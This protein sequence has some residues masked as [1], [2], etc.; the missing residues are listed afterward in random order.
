MKKWSLTLLGLC[1]AVM[2]MAQVISISPPKPAFNEKATL[3]FRA[4]EGNGSLAGHTGD[5]YLHAGL[6]TNESTS[7]G[8]WKKAVADWG[9]NKKSP[10][11]KRISEDVYELAFTVS[12][13]YGIPATGGGVVALA[14][15]FRDEKGSKVGKDEGGKDL[16]YFYQEPD[17][18]APP[19]VLQESVSR[20][21]D[22]ANYASIY[23]VNIR[24]YTPEGTFNAFAKHLPRLRELGV[25]ILWFMPVQPIGEKRR[26]GPL[27]SYYSIQ[28]YTAINPEFGTMDDFK[29]LVD[30][31][32]GMGFKV[33]LDWVA[34]HSSW[35]NKWMTRHDD[36]Y[37]RDADGNMVAPYDWTD[38]ADL[39][40]DMYYMRQAMTE[41]MLFWVQEADIDGF[42]CDVA[43]EV[44]LDFWEETR[45]QLDALKDV[46][47]LAE[48]GSQ[49]GLLNRAFNANYGWHFHHLMNEVA[50]GKSPASVL[51]PHFED[52]K[53]QYPHGTYPMQFITNHDE[54]SWAGTVYER[55]GDGHKAF[56]VLTFTV[57]GMPLIYSGQ[58]AGL[59]KRLRFFDK[60]TIDWSDQTL[61]P[62]YTQLN[63]LKAE[64]PA[65]WNGRAGGELRAMN[66]DQLDAVVAFSR[67][68]GKDKV[69]TLL[70]L[71]SKPQKAAIEVTVDAGIYTDYFTGETVTLHKRTTLTLQPWE[72]RVLIFEKELAASTRRLESIDHSPQGLRIVTNDGTVYLRALSEQAMELEF[73][74]VGESSIAPQAQVSGLT[75]IPAQL[76]KKSDGYVYATDGIAAHLSIDPL[77]VIYTRNGQKLISEEMGFFDAGDARGFRFAL[78]DG[79]RLTGGGSRVLPI[80]RRGYRLPLY[81][82][83]SYGYETHAEQ[84]YYSMPMLLSDRKYALFFDN[85]AVGTLDV[86]ATEAEILQFEAVGGRMSYTVVAADSW[87]QLPQALTAVTGRQPMLPRWALGNIASRMGYHSQAEVTDVVRRYRADDIP[88]D[89]VVLDLFWFGATVKN[90]LGNLDWH[91]DS[92]PDPVQMMADF[93]ADGVNTILITEPFVVQGTKYADEVVSQGLVGKKAD[94]SPYWYDFFF[95]HTTLLDLFNPATQRW[96]WNIY[97]QHTATG[98]A[99]WWGDLGEPEVHPDDMHHANGRMGREVHNHYGHTWAKTVFEGFERDFPERR[100]VI[101]MR[102]GAVGSQRYGLVPWSGDVNRSWGGLQPQV[103][104]SLTMGMQG[105]AYMHSDLGGFAGDYR[106]AE[107]YL[108][109]LQYG[110]FQPIYRTHAQEEVPAEPVFWDD[111]TKRIARE[112]IRLRYALM[113]YLY[114]LTHQN[115]TTGLPL[116]RPLYFLED[117]PALFDYTEA[118]LWGD[119]FLV[120]PVLTPGA[121]SQTLHLPKGHHWFNFWTDEVA[122][123]GQD[124]TQPVTLKRIPLWV[125]AGAWVPVVRPFEHMDAYHTDTL[126]VHYYH[127]NGVPRSEGYFYDDDGHTKGASS[128][129]GAHDE[130]HFNSTFDQQALRIR[131]QAEQRQS[132]RLTLVIHGLSA[133][134]ASVTVNGANAEATY[135]D[136]QLTCSFDLPN[137]DTQVV[138][139]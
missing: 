110:V 23:E 79:E 107:L 17:F 58:E 137:G 114:T 85:G 123:G 86:G 42:R 11:L 138:I 94:G 108:R 135:T 111:T 36:W 39:N 87:P 12:E 37:T 5:V 72:Y 131:I 133:N 139:Q 70:N 49:Y 7:L 51:L 61:M 103:G 74:P 106:D 101:L 90:T 41:A 125:R 81:N 44:P 105:L 122:A 28:D 56:A 129:E 92:F 33:V 54:N 88:L 100:P 113:P 40:Y 19:T 66:H 16:Y 120:A 47:M 82:K 27:G 25:D 60:D 35:D 64:H 63:S 127:H 46:W 18:K 84:M 69:V 95:G 43:G 115:A 62:F 55:L 9:D 59:N 52:I 32:H 73:L 104:L 134:A 10:K 4:A 68:K 30:K 34:N 78:S 112:Y 136:G 71:S 53:K 22:W 3:T 80:D 97:K 26:K 57:P 50:Q 20:T 1:L 96:F 93:K 77:R 8:D 21:P 121:T 45:A 29:R 76:K 98:V 109:W 38:V 89:A 67:S 119:A 102:A 15:V 126:T 116:M 132:R 118:Y 2:S 14:F 99:G 130:L 13:L 75:P 6:I 48:D 124:L 24:Q 83:P 65:L 31:A 128:R 117:D 91:R